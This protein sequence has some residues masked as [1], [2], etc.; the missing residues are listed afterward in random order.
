MVKWFLL[1]LLHPGLPV[2]IL[3]FDPPSDGGIAHQIYDKSTP[4]PELFTLCSTF[5]ESFIHNGNSFFTLYGEDEEPWIILTTWI[6]VHIG[7]WLRIRKVWVEI[8]EIPAHMM[9]SWIHVCI[10]ANT[11]TGNIS[12]VVNAGPPS[13]FTVPEL[14][15]QT[16]QNLKGK[17]VVGKS[18]N[19]NGPSQFLGYVYMDDIHPKV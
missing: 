15:L 18:E 8:R 19:K 10:S 12:A 1:L 11:A 17:L 13:F 14:T 9:N 7:L 16:P 6:S 2:K 4:L 3:T 5:K